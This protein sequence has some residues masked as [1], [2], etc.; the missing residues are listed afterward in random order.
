MRTNVNRRRCPK[1]LGRPARLLLTLLSALTVSGL[2]YAAEA[3]P[4]LL[5]IVSDRS[6]TTLVAGAHRY[7]DRNPAKEI[8]IRTVSQVDAMTDA[9]LQ[10]A[11]AEA[12]A[13]LMIAVF[14]ESVE[15]LLGLRYS[16]AQHRWV[17]QGDR[18]LLALHNDYQGEIFAGADLTA[19]DALFA[20]QSE[21]RAQAD[22]WRQT[23]EEWP[24]YGQWLQARAYWLNR[25]VNNATSLIGFVLS[26]GSDPAP[27]EPVAT[28]RFVVHRGDEELEVAGENLGDYLHSAAP[29]IWLLDHDTGD[30]PGD[31]RIHRAYCRA[32][33]WQCISVLA[34]WGEPS[35]QALGIMQSLMQQSELKTTPWSI[36]SLQDFV[37]GGG[38]GRQLVN[39]RLRAMN[40]PVLK[41]IRLTEWSEPQ[42]QISS[43]GLPGNSVHYRVAMPE[44]QGIGQAQ[45]VSV[46]STAPEDALTGARLSRNQPVTAEIARQVRRLSRWFELQRKPNAEKRIA[47]VYYNHPPGRHN[48]GADNL[49]VPESLL[50]ILLALQE[51]G[52]DVGTPPANTDELLDILQAQGVNLP[53]DRQALVDMSKNVNSVSAAQYQAW[54]QTLPNSVQSEMMHGPVGQLQQLMHTQLLQT[55]EIESLTAR[56]Q[57]L[58][59]LQQRMH[60]TCAE[61]H[62]ALDGVRHPGRERALELLDQLEEE[63]LS[64][65]ARTRNREAIDFENS[66]ALSRAIIDMAI[67]GIRG[68]GEAPGN[69]MAWDGRLLVPGVQFGNVF[70]GPQPPRGW[71][72]NEELLHANMSFPPPH[73]YLAFYHYLRDIFDADALVH[74]GRHSTYEFLPRRS[75]GLGATDYPSVIVGD[76]PSIYPYIVDGVGEGI[77]AKRRGLAI[78]VDHLTPPL[79][80]TELYD[81]L[82]QLRQLIE[83]AEA[84]SDDNTRAQAVRALRHKIDVLEL[85]EELETSMDEELQVRGVGFEQI[86]DEFL[87]HEVGHYL[88]NIQERFMPLGLHVFARDW[89]PDSVETMVA[90]MLDGQPEDMP[91]AKPTWYE[92]LVTS[93]RAERSA[94]LNALSG[95]YVAPGKGNDPIRTPDA[96]PTGRNFFALDGS[97]LPTQLGY[98]IGS[99]LAGRVLDGEAQ[100]NSEITTPA[101]SNPAG[102]KHAV[103]LW[104]SDAVRDEGA[105]IAFGMNLLGVKP[106]WNSRGIIK[107]L[108][109]LP[110]DFERLRRNDVVFTTSGLFRDLYSEHLVLLDKSV[111]MAL[112][113][114]YGVIVKKY[115]A[116]TLALQSALEPLGEWAQGGNDPLAKNDVASNWVREA[117]ALLKTN[118]GLSPAALGRQASLRVFGTAPGAYGAGINRLVE[119]SGAWNERSELG[120][121]YLQRMGHAYGTGLQGEPARALFQQ[122][123]T[124]VSNTYL[125]RAS[126]LYGLMDNNDAFDY[127]GGLNLAIETVTGKAPD[128]AVIN[129]ANSNRLRIDP[130]PQALLSELRGRFLNP[131][132]IKPLMQEGYAGARTMGSEFIEYLWGWQV[133]SPDVVDAWVWEAVKAV[134]VDDS[135]DLSLDAFLGQ[136]HN[137]QVQTN[138]LAVM[139][140]AIDKGYWEADAAT[141]SQLAEQFARNVVEAGIPGSGHTH[142]RHPIYEF[143]K[144]Q[145]P[146]DLSQALEQVLSRSRLVEESRVSQPSHIREVHLAEADNESTAA[147]AENPLPH[148]GSEASPLRSETILLLMLALA[149]LSAG[150][151]RGR[152]PN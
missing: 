46:A 10:S 136:G 129:H 79:A 87:L 92:D 152:R 94:L 99:Q 21:S 140:V 91:S 68:W 32:Q 58:D 3:A 40:V 54:F 48:I 96:L 117:R 142:A 101:T 56:L 73:Q 20:T 112:D 11:I 107:K 57:H 9:Q 127:L 24:R 31:W 80:I 78:M 62:H 17:F 36:V 44:L 147:E 84:A 132:W 123:L 151:W 102:N 18:R 76:L 110:L 95:R 74:V 119:R 148:A 115:P 1:G 86:D 130:L 59:L 137:R 45:V 104:A 19:L 52:Y 150:I 98:D 81:D 146:G 116:L 61:L 64:L 126:H 26:G 34:A 93:P 2:S 15:R 49:N 149:I 128:S 69:V 88:T 53:N 6:A 97:L 55:K 43:A 108:E 38:D 103:I 23:Q 83:S 121:V 13:L 47:I 71:E 113:A 30:R 70:L 118:P 51:Q 29:I 106:V 41:G 105:M 16:Q 138:I 25:S 100:S 12:D 77:Q 122:Q 141:V 42:W 67:E 37:I 27:V 82:L 22:I 60:K 124:Q 89:E 143:V 8:Q 75:V 5:I 131:Q 63:Y 135:L 35:E 133:T 134:Y 139:L 4:Q 72:I 28:V 109:R 120:K 39:D 90:S 66:D 111:L 33:S 144:Q 114:S 145:V 14:G 65:I 50:E 85:R 7:L 125:G